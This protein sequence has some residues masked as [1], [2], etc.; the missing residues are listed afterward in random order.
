[1]PKPTAT[2]F[3]IRTLFNNRSSKQS[4]GILPPGEQNTNLFTGCGAEILSPFINVSNNNNLLFPPSS[5]PPS[6]SH[7]THLLHL[8]QSS[9]VLQHVPQ[10]PNTITSISTPSSSYSPAPSLSANV[11]ATSLLSMG[12]SMLSISETLETIGAWRI[13]YTVWITEAWSI[14]VSSVRMLVNT[15][16][17]SLH[18]LTNL[19]L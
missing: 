15:A 18:H 9:N 5:P 8:L 6:Q 17:L 11:N 16:C 19:S 2:L 3:E 13:Q 12:P 7:N 14:L 10:T 1:M 4:K